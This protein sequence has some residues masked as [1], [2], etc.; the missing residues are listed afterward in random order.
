MR[1]NKRNL[2]KFK[3]ICGKYWEEMWEIKKISLGNRFLNNLCHGLATSYL[4]AFLLK[5]VSVFDNCMCSMLNLR[6]STVIMIARKRWH[7]HW[8]MRQCANFI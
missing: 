3:K 8:V 1:G 2:R 6:G 5:V 7:I 4:V